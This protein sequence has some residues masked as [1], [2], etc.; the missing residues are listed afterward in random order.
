MHS[1]QE[2]NLNAI[3]S[4]VKNNISSPIKKYQGDNSS[5]GLYE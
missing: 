3:G 4:S 2:N 5:R 1:Y